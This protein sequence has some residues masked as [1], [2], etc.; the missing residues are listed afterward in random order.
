MASVPVVPEVVSAGRPAAVWRSVALP[1]E[2]GG[3]GLTAEPALLGLLL[4]WSGAGVAIA[5]AALLAFLVRTP[6]KLVLVDLRRGRRLPRTGRAA[7]VVAAEGSALLLAVVV[8]LVDAGA[9]WLWPW[10]VA[11][12]FFAIELWFD[13]RSRSRRLLPEICGGVGM[14]ACV[15]AIVLA[16]EGGTALAVAAAL[17]LAGR[18]VASISFARVQVTRVRKDPT[19]RRVSDVAQV[20]GVALAA[21]AVAVD[22]DLVLGAA[23]ALVVAAVQF[24]WS[25]LPARPAKVVGIFQLVF[26][27]VIVAG[28]ALGVALA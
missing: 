28:A 11:A 22:T 7:V 2:H 5:V 20:V 27:L 24:A 18:A 26:G 15:A 19:P 12:P 3:W 1:N 10:L 16:G 9:A 8:A 21:A 4:A 23:C 14:T 17:V 25:R 13:A 6:L